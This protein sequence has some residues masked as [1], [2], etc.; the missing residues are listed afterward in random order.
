[1]ASSGGI[2]SL[3]STSLTIV[4]GMT[5]IVAPIFAVSL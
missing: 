4:H 1:M 3:G 5:A 2:G